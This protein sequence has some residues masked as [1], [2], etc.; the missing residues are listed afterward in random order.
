[1]RGVQCFSEIGKQCLFCPVFLDVFEIF[2]FFRLGLLD[3]CEDRAGI[4]AANGIEGGGICFRVPVPDEMVFDG[5]FECLFGVGFHGFIKP[6]P[7]LVCDRFAGC[8][9]NPLSCSWEGSS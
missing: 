7:F 5:S 2:P 4:D 3:E 1:M 8:I 9:I 6:V